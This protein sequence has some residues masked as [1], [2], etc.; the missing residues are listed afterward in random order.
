MNELKEKRFLND[1]QEYVQKSAEELGFDKLNALQRCLML[2]EEVGELF[3][4]IRK[5][6]GIKVDENS[7]VDTIEDELADIFLQTCAVANYFKIDL[8]KAFRDKQLK[9]TGRW[10]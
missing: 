3:K 5:H 10:R 8:E 9:N 2:G 7:K 6:E 4:S 1:V